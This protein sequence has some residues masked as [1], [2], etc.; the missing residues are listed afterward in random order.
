MYQLIFDDS[1][2]YDPRDDSLIIWDPDVHLAVGEAGSLSFTIGPDHP[3]LNKLSRMKGTVVLKADGQAIYRG[4]IRKDTLKFDLSRE[5]ETE[6]LLACLNDSLV[7]PYNFPL[8]F[9][10]DESYIEAEK[11]GNV[12]QFFLGWLLDQHNSQVGPSQRIQLG[13]V[14]VAD[15]N[16]YITRASS[17]YLTTMETV[18]KKLRD[19]LGG[20][21]VVDYSSEIPVLNYYSE[22]P[23]TNTQVVEYGENLLDLLTEND[24][25]ELFTAI[26]PIGAEGLTISTLDDYEISP[27]YFKSDKIIYSEE[28]EAQHGGIRI[29]R[30]VVWNDVTA[31]VN[32][33]RKA[34]EMLSG[35]GVQLS[36]T[37]TVKAADLGGI[38]GGLSRF[39]VG[40]NVRLQSTP[41]GFSTILPLM[42]LDPNILNPGDTDITL[43]ITVKT[44]SD[45]ANQ[46]QSSLEEQLNQQRVQM[47]SWLTDPTWAQEI[48]QSHLTSVTQ[49]T[50]QMLIEALKQYVETGNFEVYKQTV[51][52]Q[53]SVMAEEIAMN[54]TKTTEHI[55]NVDGDLQSRF[56]QLR[57]Y[58]RFTGDT[59][60]SIGSS[61]SAITLEIDN[62]SGI[63]FKKNGV[64]FGRWD[65]N[66][67]YTGN[68][69]VEVNERAQL[70]NFAF[71][72]RSDGS[73]SFLKV[74]G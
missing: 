50:E 48:L 71:V 23:L 35:E 47:D 55:D 56:T 34:L 74:G 17:D 52:S 64:P 16:N 20:Y 36:R 43:G 2:I 58:I 25:T 42:E 24:A 5:I 63:V 27:G 65:G 66:D 14:T 38:T 62:A 45:I 9:Q 44:A 49:T 32:L 73:L 39:V 1:P 59:A 46:N 13:E 54:F 69:V 12:I 70:G 10:N 15:P 18:K 53:L 40:R 11:S 3:Y 61:D 29:T 57:K 7:P 6:G 72:P 8:D 37:V 28:A 26:L 51:E 67:F 4:R 31:A 68:I 22:L 41:H 30:K 21:L 33:Q 19:L 60:I